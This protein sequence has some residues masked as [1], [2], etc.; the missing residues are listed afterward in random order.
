MNGGAYLGCRCLIHRAVLLRV[1]WTCTW[2][3]IQLTAIDRV[4]CTGNTI[5]PDI[6]TG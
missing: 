5:V 3:I 4:C 1:A 6:D 2:E